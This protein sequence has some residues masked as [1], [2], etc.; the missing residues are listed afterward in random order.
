MNTDAPIEPG[1]EAL[2]P[3]CDGQPAPLPADTSLHAVVR[4][5]YVA[6]YTRLNRL[7]RELSSV[8]THRASSGGVDAERAVLQAMD[9]VLIERDALD[10]R[11][12]LVGISATPVVRDGVVADLQFCLPGGP[13][14]VVSSFSL[15]FAVTPPAVGPDSTP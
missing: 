4:R 14:A 15:W 3:R 1:E 5:E 10:D 2:V 6:V 8:R 12:A 7:A 13:P 11:H 9:R